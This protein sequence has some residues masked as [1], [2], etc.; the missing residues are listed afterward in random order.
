MTF[1]FRE[2]KDNKYQVFEPNQ[3]YFGKI[4]RVSNLLLADTILLENQVALLTD[5]EVS[6]IFLENQV[7]ALI[8]RCYICRLQKEF[9]PLACGVSR[10]PPIQ[11]QAF[12]SY[13]SSTLFTNQVSST[14]LVQPEIMAL[15]VRQ[16]IFSGQ[17]SQMQSIVCQ[18]MKINNSSFYF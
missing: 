9:L 3:M 18:R 17:I 15:I 11:Y 7:M 5:Q 4:S 1:A 2:K 13:G 8:L 12:A 14:L 10:Q 16:Q 6:T